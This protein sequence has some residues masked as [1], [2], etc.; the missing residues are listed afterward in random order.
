MGRR[1]A[2][3]ISIGRYQG[4]LVLGI[5][6][7]RD[8]LLSFL[9]LPMPMLWLLVLGVVLWRWPAVSRVLTLGATLLRLV[10]SLPVSGKILSA[11]LVQGAL[12]AD[13]YPGDGQA[14]GVTP[15]VLVPTAGTF[16]ARPPATRSKVWPRRCPNPWPRCRY[17]ERDAGR[18]RS[19]RAYRQ[20][21]VGPGW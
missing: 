6:F 18:P 15:I 19:S 3:A 10:F 5:V 16:D 17:A 8:V 4:L 21:L 20:G 13:S 1:I 2:R 11:Y 14:L 12:P 9:V 7:V